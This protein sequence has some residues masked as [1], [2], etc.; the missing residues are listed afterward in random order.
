MK[1]IILLF[2]LIF[3]FTGCSS[4]T[5][6]NELNIVDTLGIDYVDNKYYLFMNVVDG[7]LE[8]DEIEEKFIT[9]QTN[10]DTLEECFHKIYLQSPKRLYLSH[11]D[12]LILT[13]DAINNKFKDIINN[14]LKNNEYRNNFSVVLLKDIDLDAFMKKQIPAKNVNNLIKT[15]HKETGITKQ[16][17]LESMM[18]ELLID[19]NTYLPTI[20]F[21]NDEV[22]IDGF[23]LIKNYHVFEQLSELESIIFNLLQNEITKTYIKNNNILENQTIITTKKNNIT[24]RLVTTI[25]EDNDFKK[26]LK[27]DILA[28]LYKYQNK[29]Y[30]ILKLCEKIRRNDYNYYKRTYDLLPKLTYN[31]IFNTTE[32]ENYLQGDFNEK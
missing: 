23:T 4:Y 1:K 7:S 8:N 15:N 17:D 24:F 31:V 10:G 30:D 9:Y 19:N 32:K 16:Q 6:L 25:M 26:V 14:F 29:D 2:S 18:K 21:I 20:Q 27:D 28:F 11:I 3:I 13:D 5:E 22:V 12:L